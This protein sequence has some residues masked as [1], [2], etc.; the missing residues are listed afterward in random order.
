MSS[1][2][3]KGCEPQTRNIGNKRFSDVEPSIFLILK[4][5]SLRHQAIY[6]WKLQAKCQVS[7]IKC[8]EHKVAHELKKSTTKSIC[9]YSITTY[10]T[11]GLCCSKAA[12]LPYNTKGWG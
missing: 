4:K 2:Y 8:I 11:P 12:T 1:F 3:N 6:M 9:H 7:T 5:V 10:M